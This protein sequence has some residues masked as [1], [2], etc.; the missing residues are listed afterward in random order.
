MSFGRYLC[1][2]ALA[3][4]LA[5]PAALCAEGKTAWGGASPRTTMSG[6]IGDV[7]S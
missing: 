7:D 4:L 3:A 2:L 6:G 5:P 1:L